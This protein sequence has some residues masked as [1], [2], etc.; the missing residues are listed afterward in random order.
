MQD[1]FTVAFCVANVVVSNNVFRSVCEGLYDVP[2]TANSEE[3]NAGRHVHPESD[4]QRVLH[5]QSGPRTDVEGH[6]SR[7]LHS[8][9]GSSH[10]ERGSRKTE[11]R[12]RRP[13][14][15]GIVRVETLGGTNRGPTQTG[16]CV[17]QTQGI[18]ET[19]L[20]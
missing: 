18:N 11:A 8:R 6:P 15:R 9:L 5:L 1:R 20:L 12:V 2:R 17:A 3:E 4:L 13:D 10:E 7:V 14:G 16:R 19:T